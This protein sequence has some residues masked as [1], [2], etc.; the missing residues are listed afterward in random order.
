MVMLCNHHGWHPTHWLW[1]HSSQSMR[2]WAI[3]C[4]NET[5]AS[6]PATKPQ[7]DSAFQCKAYNC[8]QPPKTR[9]SRRWNKCMWGILHAYETS[10]PQVRIN[11]NACWTLLY[12]MTCTYC[13]PAQPRRMHQSTS[14]H[15]RGHHVRLQVRHGVCK[16]YSVG[17]WLPMQ[18]EHLRW[19]AI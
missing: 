7:Q 3:A 17:A 16:W 14:H 18:G 4:M 8:S 11:L 19:M 2:C 15:G 12:S 9:C 10:P 1:K 5:S 6:I 13:A